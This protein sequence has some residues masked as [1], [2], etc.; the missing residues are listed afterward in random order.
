[1]APPYKPTVAQYEDHF[2]NGFPEVVE[3]H[4]PSELP[5]LA[6]GQEWRTVWQ[7]LAASTN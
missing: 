3:L 5:I 1:M 6:P 4:L 7:R 2:E